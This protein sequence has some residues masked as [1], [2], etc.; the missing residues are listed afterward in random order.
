MDNQKSFEHV[1]NEFNKNY[2]KWMNDEKWSSRLNTKHGKKNSH[3]PR[4]STFV[5][6]HGTRF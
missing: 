4:K 2:E 1:Q 6:F 3:V 5:F